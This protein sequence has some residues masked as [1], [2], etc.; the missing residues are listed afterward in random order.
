MPRSSYAGHVLIWLVV[1][2]I[3]FVGRRVGA[4]PFP[5]LMF[6]IMSGI[7]FFGALWIIRQRHEGTRFFAKLATTIIIATWVVAIG[8][9]LN[10]DSYP[11]SF[12]TRPDWYVE[13]MD[14]IFWTYAACPPLL[15]LL[16]GILPAS[17]ETLPDPAGT[18][19]A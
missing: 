6:L 7:Y 5:H 2:A 14:V 10:P 1:F 16:G 15:L 12:A 17:R 4:L 9:Y 18:T 3:V 11:Y 8:V 13:M 19:P